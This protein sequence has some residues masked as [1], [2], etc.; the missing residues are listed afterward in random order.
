[1]QG[2]VLMM[3]ADLTVDL[4]LDDVKEDLIKE[5]EGKVGITME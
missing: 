4:T 5:A 1:M 3:R 2:R